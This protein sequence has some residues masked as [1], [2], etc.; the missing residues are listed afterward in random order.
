MCSLREIGVFVGL[1]ED[2]LERGTPSPTS[3]R[4]AGD[5]LAPITTIEQQRSLRGL[6]GLVETLNVGP[7]TLDAALRSPRQAIEPYNLE[8]TIG[9]TQGV[10]LSTRIHLF[11]SGVERWGG[12][13]YGPASGDFTPTGLAP[14]EWDVV[15]RRSGLENTGYRRLEK[16]LGRVTVTRYVP[17]PAPPPPS[18]APT[19]PHID[20]Q[21]SGPAEAKRYVV[22]GTGFLPNQPSGF[23]GIAVRAVDGVQNQNWVLLYTGS[24]ASGKISLTTG[25]L[26]TTLLPRNAAGQAIV[27]F[28]AADKRTN[29]SSVPANQPLWSNTVTFRYSYG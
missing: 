8:V 18:P 28:S 13:N 22:T 20:V 14:G 19:A 25:E 17:P 15:V 3:L 16:S 5:I 1:P 23:Q 29:P 27:H 7:L 9:P 4:D 2:S 24:D 6:C 10:V 12:P 21:E 26:D 11:Q